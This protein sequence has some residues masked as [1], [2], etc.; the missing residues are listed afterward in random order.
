MTQQNYPIGIQT[1]SKI[2]EEGYAYVD[3]TMFIPKLIESGHYLFLSRPRRF[4]KSLLLSTLEAYFEGQR[5]LFKGLAIDKMGVEWKKWPVLRIDLNSQDYTLEDGLPVMLNAI[6]RDY[7]AL[8]NITRKDEAIPIRFASLIK[9]IYEETGE[10]VVILVDEYDK[11]LTA[12]EDNPGLFAKNQA[13]LKGFYGVLKSMDQYIRFAMLTGVA[14]FNKV[15]IFSDLNNLKDISLSSA[16]ADICGWT[17]QE[18]ESTFCPGIEA[19]AEKN[20]IDYPEAMTRLENFYDGYLFASGGSR[21][22]NPFSVLNALSDQELGYYWYQTGT[23]TFLAK[24]VR[25][26]KIRLSSMS[27]CRATE[28]QLLAVGLNDP[29]PIPLLFQT[30]YLTIKSKIGQRYELKFPNKEVETGFAENLLPLYL[31]PM[32]DING[33]FSIWDFQDEIIDG[34][35]EKF[36]VRFQTML[37]NIPYE[38]HDEQLYQNAVYL[39]FTLLGTDSRL[40]EHTNIGSTDLTVRTKDYIYLFEFKYHRSSRVAIDQIHDRDY[41]GRFA[42]DGRTL[43]LIGANFSLDARGLE[44]WVIEKV[45]K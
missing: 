12:I 35:P 18:L 3:K 29:N 24:R 33:P 8:Y 17:R 25:N 41:A 1:F 45:E 16:F 32:E 13:T 43:F 21:L 22:Y 37:K 15:S 34:E 9:G 26:A 38:K 30:G 6:L 10:K 2:I 4:G 28:S 27:E 44:D 36:M 23:P 5:E 31:P 40:E 42:L 14:R 11:P 39:I 7:E 20:N 19:L